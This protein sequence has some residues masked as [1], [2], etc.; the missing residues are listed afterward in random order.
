MLEE[1]VKVKVKVKGKGNVKGKEHVKVTENVKENVKGNVKEHAKEHAKVTE[2]VK[3]TEHAKENVKKPSSP[4][5]CDMDDDIVDVPPLPQT[6][7]KESQVPQTE[8]ESQVPQSE[9]KC[10]Y[11]KETGVGYTN[12]KKSRWACEECL[13]SVKEQVLASKE[14]EA[15][16]LARMKD[17]KCHYLGCGKT[18][19]GYTSSAKHKK[20][21]CKECLA[22]ALK[23]AEASRMTEEE[24]LQQWK[25]M[26]CQYAY[27]GKTGVCFVNTN[28]KKWACQDCSDAA[29]SQKTESMSWN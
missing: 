27:C 21:A 15:E 12:S 1:S 3:V 16:H 14:T 26:K 2:N 10:Y 9:E 18:G 13:T 8:K 7:K 4:K 28:S 5:W 20:W 23:Q 29:Y 25:G 19:V 17:T 6:A 22:A 11:C 24:Y